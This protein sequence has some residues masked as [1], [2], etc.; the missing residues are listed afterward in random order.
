MTSQTT[1]IN[2]FACKDCTDIDY[3]KKHIDPAHPK[4]GPYDINKPKAEDDKA[5]GPA[6]PA[7][8][9]AGAVT[10][11]GAIDPARREALKPVRVEGGNLDVKS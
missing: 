8:L 3:A 5:K 11:P 2:G 1:T 10:G 4:N 7:V 6:D 9:Y